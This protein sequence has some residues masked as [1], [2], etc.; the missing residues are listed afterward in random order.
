MSQHS[1][2]LVVSTLLTLAWAIAT[3]ADVTALQNFVS[4]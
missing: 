1:S 3:C 4:R 2:S